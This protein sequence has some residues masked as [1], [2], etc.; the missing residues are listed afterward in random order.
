MNNKELIIFN[1]NQKSFTIYDIINMDL[2]ELETNQIM[3]LKHE[4]VHGIKMNNLEKLINLAILD[5]SKVSS[6][7][8]GADLKYIALDNQKRLE[9]IYKLLD[10]F[11]QFK[12]QTKN[13]K[14]NKFSC[15]EDSEIALGYLYRLKN[16]LNS[17]IEHGEF[18]EKEMQENYNYV[19]ELQE[20]ER[21]LLGGGE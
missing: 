12:T 1:N 21:K 13:L 17:A 14:R 20:N 11:D 18:K 9:L 10:S 8:F 5:L 7:S 19:R 3:N 16:L 4:I 15:N 6:P 2:C